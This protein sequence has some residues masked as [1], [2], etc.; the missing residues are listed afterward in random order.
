MCT[1]HWLTGVG[2]RRLENTLIE[3]QTGRC[4]GID[5][6]LVFDAGISLPVPEFVPFRLTT[7]ILGLLR[8]FTEHD[9][10]ATTMC[11]VLRT[12]RD[13]KNL[14]SAIFN[15]TLRESSDWNSTLKEK[16]KK[17]NSKSTG[18]D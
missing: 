7:Q 10:F 9:L 18:N 17:D 4:F 2:D 3:I 16:L 15:G 14:I 1:V 5:F 11:H 6:S 13:D 8:P 12:L